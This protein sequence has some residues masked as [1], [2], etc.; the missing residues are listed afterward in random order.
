MR[1]RS[2][3]PSCASRLLAGQQGGV[4]GALHHR[5]ARCAALEH[6]SHPPRTR[7]AGEV[8]QAQPRLP[9]RS[10][11]W[12]RAGQL[13]MHHAAALAQ[14]AVMCTSHSRHPAPTHTPL[15]SHL[16]LPL[17]PCPSAPAAHPERC[18]A[19]WSAC[20]VCAQPARHWSGAAAGQGQH[21][22]VH[23]Q[24]APA[25]QGCRGGLAGKPQ[26]AMSTSCMRGGN[27]LPAWIACCPWH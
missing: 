26:A 9:S 23:V 25:Q 15:P 13:G 19:L 11:A 27:G 18:P 10:N 4:R 8:R 7:A 2:T 20:G 6:R 14:T 24:I 5:G 17:C 12:Q 3:T 1:L 22:N 21:N 16:P